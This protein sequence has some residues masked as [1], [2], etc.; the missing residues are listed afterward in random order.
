MSIGA[1]GGLEIG[2]SKDLG[3]LLLKAGMGG[4]IG[5]EGLLEME[6]LDGRV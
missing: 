6:G 1:R 3:I 4:C 5:L 2:K